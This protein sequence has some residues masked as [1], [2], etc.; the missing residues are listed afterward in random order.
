MCSCFHL[1][2]NTNKIKNNKPTIGETVN[3]QIVR[4]NKIINIIIPPQNLVGC[5]AYGIVDL[6]GKPSL[7]TS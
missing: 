7:D 6:Y 4:P 3:D 2:I 5:P 1:L